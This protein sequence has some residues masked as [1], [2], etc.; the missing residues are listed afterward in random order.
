MKSESSNQN[1][2]KK[3]FTTY[4]SVLLKNKVIVGLV[5]K[6]ISFISVI[7]LSAIAFI[8]Y[9]DETLNQHEKILLKEKKER[10]IYEQNNIVQESL[11]VAG[12]Y[13]APSRQIAIFQNKLFLNSKY[14]NYQII[15]IDVNS[16]T[17][18]AQFGIRMSTSDLINNLNTLKQ[19]SASSVE[20]ELARESINQTRN[21]YEYILS[22]NYS[23]SINISNYTLR[24]DFESTF[25]ISTNITI[26]RF[27][28]N[29]D[30]LRFISNP[31]LVNYVNS[32]KSDPNI[33]FI[34][35]NG[36][37]GYKTTINQIANNL[38]NSANKNGSKFYSTNA[39]IGIKILNDIPSISSGA[40]GRAYIGKT[41][42]SY[43]EAQITVF[44][45]GGK[46]KENTNLNKI[47]N[48]VSF[49]DAP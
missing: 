26:Q 43:F 1:S 7:A 31:Q 37:Y 28:S 38:I 9:A 8:W 21:S 15:S 23:S 19:R 36:I 45:T 47:K 35:G 29:S 16:S 20:K 22:T 39:I 3:K 49:E 41:S 34:I 4:I 48:L 46:S 32:S 18:M 6:S 27:K 25:L 14:K 24:K 17:E 44:I 12:D 30:Y 11:Y 40:D 42:P 13:A 33:P 10:N 2:F 5:T